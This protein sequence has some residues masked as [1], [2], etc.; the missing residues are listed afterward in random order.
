MTNDS[1]LPSIRCPQ[2]VLGAGR[3]GIARVAVDDVR[4]QLIA[5]FHAPITLPQ[6]SYLLDPSSYALTGG[7]RLFP[8]IL[9]AELHIRGSPPGIDQ[10]SVLLSLDG[11]GDFSIY[12]LTVS[13]PDIDPFFRS[14]KLRFR[15]AC[16]DRFDCRPPAA[17]PTPPSESP[18]AIDYLAKDYSSF[19]QAL[20]DFIPSRLPAWEERSAA[21]LGVMLLEL[22]AATADNLSYL[23]DR[24]ANEAFLNSAT[25]RRSVAGHLALIG[26]QMDEGAS[27]HTW[28]QFQ[29]N[30]VQALP[31]NPGFKVSNRPNT[32]DEPVILFET[33][34]EATLDPRHN[35]M[36]LYTWGNEECC[37]PQQALHAALSD[38][39]DGLQAG[40]YLLFDDGRGHRDVVR[41]TAHP[42]IVMAETTSSPP[43]GSPPIGSPPAGLVTLVSWSEAT[44]LH[45]DYCA[46][47]VIVRG[48]LVPATHGETVSETLRAPVDKQQAQVNAEIAARKPWQRIP[49]Q[50]LRL[51][52]VPLAHLDPDTLLLGAPLSASASATAQDLAAALAARAPRSVSTLQVKVDGQDW[53]EQTSLLGSRPDSQDF[54]VEIDDLGKATVVFGNG[55]FGLRPPETAETTAT[56]RVGGGRMGIVGADTLIVPHPA[57]PA[58]WLKSVTNPVP[59]VGGRDLESRDHARRV[60]PAITRDALVAVSAADYQAAA[61]GFIERSGKKPVQRANASFRW[62]GSWLTVTLA[63]DPRGTEGLAP[64]LRLELLSYLEK[65]R[66]AGYDLELSG[67]VYVPIEL[68]IEFCAAPDARPSDVQQALQQTLSNGDLPGGLK[69]FFHPDNFTFG[70]NLYVSRIYAAVMSVQGIESAQVTKLA[71]LHAA[72]PEAETTLNLSQGYLSVGPDQIIRLDNDRSFPQ[73]GTLTIRAKGAGI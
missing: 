36:A 53:K 59:A 42:E 37:L 63:V 43:G 65:K 3:Q 71:R 35:Q 29:V 30:S 27:A 24:G 72:Q 7:Q 31:A 19:R 69:G 13:G 39:F 2:P 25:Q 47:D 48:N 38:S 5:S 51:S 52:H 67:P 10:P 33:L 58:P 8:R 20:L 11:L 14:A 26:Y 22:F 9:K 28:L 54:R 66:L 45:Y 57:A 21:D 50:R 12:T 61:T 44:P 41:L 73:N 56:Y 34:A 4:A 18:V 32:A 15:L 40:D 1:H 49:R 60:G 6:Q 23:Q 16:E 68:E 70:D 17:L 46:S 55:I 64:G 62:T